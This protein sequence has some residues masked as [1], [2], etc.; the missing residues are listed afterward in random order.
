V[1]IA[2]T[3]EYAESDEIGIKL[4]AAEMGIDLIYVPFR[5]ISTTFSEEGY[6]FRS[7]GKNYMQTIEDIAVILNRA[8][9]KNRRL[10]AVSFFEALNKEVLN[11]SSV[12]NL[13]SSKF[14]TLL[15]LWKNEI[16]IPKTVYIPCDPH[17]F[18][19]DEREVQNEKDITNLLSHELDEGVVV[20]PDCG[21]HGVG[22]QL[23]KGRT[24]LQNIIG[25]IEPSVLNPIGVL[26]QEYVDKW[27]YD[28]RIIVAKERGKSSYCYPK[29]MA[30]GGFADFRTNT[31][32]GNKVFG[33]DLPL[34]IREAAE[35]CG[36]AIGEGCKSWMLAL[37]A[38]LEIG[39]DKIIEDECIESLLKETQPSFNAVNEVKRNKR[40]IKNFDVWNNK[41][42]TAYQKYKDTEAY[43]KIKE[44]IEESI[45][46]KKHTIK[47]HEA[48]S[49]PEFWEQ[50]RLTAEINIGEVLLKCAQSLI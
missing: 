36:K 45:N 15:C 25:R 31:Y 13:C 2:I 33:V 37:D 9:S 5:K 7:I 17:G 16:S 22:V 20:K 35:K 14:K 28:L 4:T 23:A 43:Q 44:I 32:L 11:P 19:T 3:Y 50:T 18:L 1:S 48:N 24:E 38:M 10:Y 40:R 27:F 21:T 8:Q 12:E 41:L 29:A 6:G 34:F 47:F 26:A 46:M 42:E 49:C 30:R 39:D